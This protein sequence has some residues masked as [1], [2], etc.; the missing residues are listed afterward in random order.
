MRTDSPTFPT[1]EILPKY[2]A[3][4]RAFQCLNARGAIAHGKKITKGFTYMEDVQLYPSKKNNIKKNIHSISPTI[5][6]ESMVAQIFQ[7]HGG[8]YKNFN[9]DTSLI[10]KELLDNGPVVSLSFRPTLNFIKTHYPSILQQHIIQHEEDLEDIYCEEML[11]VGWEMTCTGEVWLCQSSLQHVSTL[12]TP[13]PNN[14]TSKNFTRIACCQFGIDDKCIAP[15]SRIL[16]HICWQ[17]GPYFDVDFSDSP[18]W[19]EWEEIEL[20][21]VDSELKKM[22]HIFFPHGFS[23]VFSDKTHIVLRDMNKPAHC[24]TYKASDLKWKDSTNEWFMILVRKS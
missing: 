16:D 10:K 14:S 13:L 1:T 19:R 23:K 2:L 21:L 12:D 24:N 22:F 9:S 7:T 11:I 4:L 5:T 8:G 18:E 17:A 15:K 6:K 3:A 20:P